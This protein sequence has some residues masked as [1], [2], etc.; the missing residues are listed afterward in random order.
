MPVVEE[1]ELVQPALEEESPIVEVGNAIPEASTLPPLLIEDIVPVVE[2]VE[3]LEPVILEEAIDVEMLEPVI[4]EEIVSGSP[5]ILTLPT[6]EELLPCEEVELVEPVMLEEPSDVW[7]LIAEVDEISLESFTIPSPL[8]E[9]IEQVEPIPLEETVRALSATTEITEIPNAPTLP[10]LS[11]EDIAP[12]VEEVEIVEQEILQKTVGVIPE[13][14]NLTA[15]EKPAACEEME[16]VKPVILEEPV[17]VLSPITKIDPITPD[18]PTL[19]PISKENVALLIKDILLQKPDMLEELIKMFPEFDRA[20]TE[21]STLTSLY[22]EEIDSKDPIVLKDYT[23]A[24]ASDPETIILDEHIPVG[25]EILIDPCTGMK[26]PAYYMSKNSESF[27]IPGAPKISFSEAPCVLVENTYIEYIDSP[28]P[29]I[30]TEPVLESDKAEYFIPEQFPLINSEEGNK[31]VIM[32]DS[33]LMLPNQERTRLEL[34]KNQVLQ[35]QLLWT[36]FLKI[37][38]TT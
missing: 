22:I 23:D 36:R 9:D 21:A 19:S 37:I 30:I 35:I 25:E 20:M 18:A 29:T 27:I 13:T 31:D 38:L 15:V 10:S 26:E 4:L 6:I 7:S 12:A 34:N 33:G 17:G 11:I 2:N 24:F 3:V 28:K 14:T 16:L 5:E 1:V 8:I 32:G